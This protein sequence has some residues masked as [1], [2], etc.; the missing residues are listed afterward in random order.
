[1]QRLLALVVI[2]CGINPIA[3]GGFS[4]SFEFDQAN[5]NVAPGDGPISIQLLL[6]EETNN[7]SIPRLATGGE[8]GFFQMGL[9]VNYATFTGG[10]SM[11]STFTP[12]PGISEEGNPAVLSLA[13]NVQIQYFSA[14]ATNGLEVGALG[15][16]TTAIAVLGTFTFTNPN[17]IGVTTLTLSDRDPAIGFIDN[18]FTDGT[19]IDFSDA[20]NDLF[21]SF[22]SSTIT[23]AVTAVPEPTSLGIAGIAF[24]AFAIRRWKQKR[25]AAAQS[26]DVPG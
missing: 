23:V 5:Y 11:F 8:N 25:K 16:N 20:A 12:A 9:N 1:M 18:I 22:G 10:Q 3:F 2:L 17:V 7:G 4:Y 26:L 13:N 21:V 15:P 19:S 6:R 24:G 14:D